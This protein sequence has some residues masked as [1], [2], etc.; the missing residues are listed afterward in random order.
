MATIYVSDNF[1]VDIVVSEQVAHVTFNSDLNL[2]NYTFK[3]CPDE[4]INGHNFIKHTL[5]HDFNHV[6]K[7]NYTPDEFIVKSEGK[8]P[9]NNKCKYTVTYNEGK[10]TITCYLSVGKEMRVDITKP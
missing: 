8:D 10:N 3:T 4:K 1:I 7:T 6:Y 2:E 9:T 5:A